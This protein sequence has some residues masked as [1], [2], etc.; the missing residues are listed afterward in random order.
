MQATAMKQV[1]TTPAS[2]DDRIRERAYELYQQRGEHPGS[3]VEDWL[4]AESEILAETEAS[5][6]EASQE[7][8]PASDSPAH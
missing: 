2:P 1:A 5:V 3:D 8:F 6:D 4:R 7:S